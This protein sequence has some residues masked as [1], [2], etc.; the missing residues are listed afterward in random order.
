MCR[1]LVLK[2]L[3]IIVLSSLIGVLYNQLSG[4]GIPLV[5]SP[6]RVIKSSDTTNI[7]TTL[8]STQ[9]VSI[10][11]E[12]AYNLFQKNAAIFLDARTEDEYKEGHIK[13][14]LNL[15]FENFQVKF[16]S[17]A[18]SLKTDKFIITYCSGTECQ[19]S[20]HL[21]EVLMGMRYKKVRVFFGGWIEWTKANYPTETSQ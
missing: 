2:S 9:I 10:T 11:L 21:A 13:G 8:I 19:S 7:D 17:V 5:A 18:D 4:K 15:P 3:F 16:P 20:I 6:V 12:E 14:S 1:S